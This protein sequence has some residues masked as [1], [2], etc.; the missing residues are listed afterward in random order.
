MRFF[1]FTV[2]NVVGYLNKHFISEN[3]SHSEERPC[4]LTLAEKQRNFVRATQ[5][6][7]ISLR[8]SSHL[9][10]TN[11]ST[12]ESEL[13]LRESVQ[14]HGGIRLEH[15]RTGHPPSHW[16]T[17]SAPA[18]TPGRPSRYRDSVCEGAAKGA[19]SLLF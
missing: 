6:V 11:M 10:D 12:R 2:P 18:A 15:T 14:V 3:Y 8:A 7:A 16:R 17:W 13:R 5:N 4:Y 1:K 19:R 9:R